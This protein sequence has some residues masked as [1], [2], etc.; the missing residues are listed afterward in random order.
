M[1]T[2]IRRVIYEELRLTARGQEQT[3]WDDRNA[4]YLD[5]LHECIHLLKYIDLYT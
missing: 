4:Q 1:L 5:K 2:E 3:S